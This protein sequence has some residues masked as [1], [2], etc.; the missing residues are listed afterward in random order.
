MLELSANL[1]EALEQAADYIASSDI[2]VLITGTEIPVSEGDPLCCWDLSAF[3]PQAFPASLKY[4]DLWKI[5]TIEN[6]PLN[7][8]K[9]WGA[10]KE[11]HDRCAGKSPTYGAL[12]VLLERMA[13][14]SDCN[15]EM[16]QQLLKEYK[17]APSNPM[18]HA[19]N[20]GNS[21]EE[22][23]TPLRS[24]HVITSA[25]DGGWYRQT[26]KEEEEQEQG[27]SSIPCWNMFGDTLWWCCCHCQRLQ[28]LPASTPFPVLGNHGNSNDIEEVEVEV[29][30]D[31]KK[32]SER[33]SESGGWNENEALEEDICGEEERHPLSPSPK[34]QP[35]TVTATSPSS[36]SVSTT[37]TAVAASPVFVLPCQHCVHGKLRPNIQCGSS[38]RGFIPNDRAARRFWRWWSACMGLAAKKKGH[39]LILQVGVTE[40]DQAAQALTDTLIVMA[41]K[42]DGIGIRIGS[43]LASAEIMP[44]PMPNVTLDIPL[45]VTEA[46]QWLL[47]VDGSV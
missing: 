7:F 38:D 39:L 32:E 30:L 36:F 10:C 31:L 25:L 43:S 29:E 40:D 44:T 14:R 20:G 41:A 1:R 15:S 28:L 33:E 24:F 2:C 42:H 46:M 8:Y 23:D 5:E 21:G 45:E 17:S 22:D 9:F 4:D 18:E 19:L 47:R 34:H 26:T 6:D 12:R 13:Q 27:G 35:H 11:R 37:T 16:M 3:P